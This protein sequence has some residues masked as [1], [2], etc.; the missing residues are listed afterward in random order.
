MSREVWD[1]Y[2]QK[3][4]KEGYP[5]RSVYKLI[6]IQEKL[7]VIRSSDRVLDIGCAPGSWSLYILK[8]L[9]KGFLVGVDFLPVYIPYEKSKAFFL[10][11]SVESLF[12]ELKTL[13]SFDVI[14]SDAAPKTTGNR[15]VDTGRSLALC[16]MIIQLSLSLLKK[17][18]NLVIKF[19]QGGDEEYLQDT[20]K[21][22]F[23]TVKRIKPKAV[24][25]ESF[26]IYLVGLGFQLRKEISS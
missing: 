7:K 3:A 2:S 13:G 4:K 11:G 23:T 5:A 17:G 19:F 24:R 1:V 16:E 20:L 6:E 22:H 9:K 15:L 26:E 14:V 21:R 25:K 8:I 12:E 18:G 10:E